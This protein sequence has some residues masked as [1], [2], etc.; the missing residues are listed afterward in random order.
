MGA[1]LV[2][3]VANT[4]NEVAGDGTTTATVLAQAVVREG[5]R[6]V[7]E[8]GNPVLLKRGIESAVRQLVEQLVR[9]SRPVGSKAEL[10]QI[11]SISVNNDP[12]IRRMIRRAGDGV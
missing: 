4:T 12:D 6:R 1:Q 11:A 7:S 10:A 5:M 9:A 3:E 2:K 8:G